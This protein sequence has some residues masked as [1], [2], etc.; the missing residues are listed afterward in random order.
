MLAMNKQQ[1]ALIPSL[2]L[3]YSSFVFTP[4]SK[5][6]TTEIRPNKKKQRTS[7][8]SSLPL[9]HHREINFAILLIANEINVFIIIALV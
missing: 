7:R 4:A 6:L 1:H 5:P 9:Q 2:N 3:Q 8:K